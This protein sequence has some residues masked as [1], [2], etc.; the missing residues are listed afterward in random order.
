MRFILL[1]GHVILSK[2]VKRCLVLFCF[3]VTIIDKS[4]Q[5]KELTHFVVRTSKLHKLGDILRG[6]APV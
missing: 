4:I 3:H 2:Q 6:K 1:L 5:P